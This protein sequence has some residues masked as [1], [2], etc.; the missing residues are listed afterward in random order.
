MRHC[1]RRGFT[2]IEL[3]VVIAII[4]VLIALLLPAVQAARE[5][6]RRAQ[7]TNNLKQMGLA[8]ANFES[9]N[10]VLP[11]A[12]GPHPWEGGGAR[13]TPA[14]L[15]LQYLEQSA[16]YG[17]F[18]FEH[19]LNLTGATSP[20]NTAQTQIVSAY[21][22]PSD[23]STARL[24]AGSSQLGYT[25]YFASVG[26]SAA[27][28]A[29][30]QYGFQEPNSN[31]FGVFTFRMNRGEPAALP[32]GRRN[33]KHREVKGNPLSMITDGTSNT[34][35]FAETLRS[36]AVNNN[37]SEVPNNSL[38]TVKFLSGG[39]N[40][41]GDERYVLPI[42]KCRGAGAYIRYRG[43]QY[44]RNLP[45]NNYYSHT[46]PPNYEYQDCMDE[47]LTQGHIA[48]RSRHPGGV[49]VVSVDGSVR[50]VKD[51]VN[52]EAW[53]ALGTMAGGEVIS[54]DAL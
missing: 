50:F 51:S 8:A 11:P 10:G 26:A 4:G 21:V 32:D 7:C 15:V 24:L 14:A 19:N 9:T 31:K 20:N 54:S 41:V 53:R 23:P 45:T 52:I 44:Y 40:F 46:M 38:L 33:P 48:A 16:A 3:L 39:G 18:N 47:S 6:A 2:L 27:N 22:C 37:A 5:A 42:D 36:Q 13:A 12:Y 28:E 43:Q 17:A 25:N 1:Q 30:S 35:L 49:N 34:A 29:G